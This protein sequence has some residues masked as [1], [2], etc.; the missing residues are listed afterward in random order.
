M[1]RARFLA[2]PLL[3][4]CGPALDDDRVGESSAG[5]GAATKAD[6]VCASGGS[7]S[8]IQSAINAAA[9]GATITICAGTYKER[10]TVSKSVTLDGAGATT[11]LDANKSGSAVTLTGGASLT[12]KDMKLTNARTSGVSCSSS[13]LSASNVSFV[14]NK[15]S[16]GGAIYAKSC[17]LSVDSS[18]FTTNS[19]SSRGGAIFAESSSGTV[20]GS[21]FTTNKASSKGGGVASKTGALTLSGNTFTDNAGSSGGGVYLEDDTDLSGNTFSSNDAVYHGGGVYSEGGDGDYTGNAFTDNYAGEDG[22][23]LYLNESSAYVADNTFTGNDALDDAGALRA[24]TSTATIEDNVF[25]ANTAADSGGAVKLSHKYG[26]FARNTLTDNVAGTTGGGLYL[27]EDTTPVEDCHFEGNTAVTGAGMYQSSGWRTT[28]VSDTTFVDNAASGNGGGV[29]V[30]LVPYG[31]HL[32]RVEL[33]GNTAANGAGVHA[34]TSEVE[35]ENVILHWNVASGSGGGVYASASATKV[36]NAVFYR[37]SAASGAALWVSADTGD[38]VRNSVV[39]KNRAG[40]AVTLSS[41][42]LPWYYN[43]HYRND[44]GEYSGMSNPAGS[45]GNVNIYPYFGDA[46][47][48]DFTLTSASKMINA[49]DP[50]ILDADG[51]RSDMGA[52][53]GPSGSGW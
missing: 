45:N 24:L 15:G 35:L 20:S 37:N 4:A 38:G 43:N 48:G 2:L 17:A 31:V 29:G 52:Y 40:Y 34:D 14:S 39:Y 5:W 41:G 42:S 26:S 36:T 27:D 3:A 6:T 8:T 49:G 7:Y 11:V 51:S 12:L 47:N 25:D 46:S 1:R 9:S 44:G 16:Y 28:E 22:G 32:V 13:T 30:Y 18:T 19:A 53:G 23:G 10:L 21:S 33:D 50:A